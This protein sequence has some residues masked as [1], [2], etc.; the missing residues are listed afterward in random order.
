MTEPRPTLRQALTVLGGSVVV[1]AFGCAGF[2]AGAS[3]GSD[4]GMVGGLVFVLG[5]LAF[6]VG[7]VLL[8]IVGIRAIFGRRNEPDPPDAPPT[9]PSSPIDRG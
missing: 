8:L 9:A 5:V 2:M 7:C 4:G 3:I 6:L 1:A